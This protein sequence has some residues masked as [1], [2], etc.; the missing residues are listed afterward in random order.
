MHALSAHTGEGVVELLG[1]IGDCARHAI[2]PEEPAL[3]TRQRHRQGI[4]DAALALGRITT[5]V[6]V[7]VAAEELRMAAR[8]LGAIIGLVS[9]EDV[10]GEIFG[11]FCIGK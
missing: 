4:G 10:L 5:G 6:P 7:E 3:M 11:R 8:S 1:M 2:R 9:P